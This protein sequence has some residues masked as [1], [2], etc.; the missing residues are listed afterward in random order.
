MIYLGPAPH[1]QRD[2]LTKLPSN[3][4]GELTTTLRANPTTYLANFDDLNIEA[5]LFKFH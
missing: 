5:I 2:A 4:L 3:S 1:K